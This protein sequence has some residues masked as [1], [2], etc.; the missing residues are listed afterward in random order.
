MQAAGT[1]QENALGVSDGDI[2][3]ALEP[4]EKRHPP[5]TGT[6]V[7]HDLRHRA[8]G[9]ERNVESAAHRNLHRGEAFEAGH[10]LAQPLRLDVGELETGGERAV[11]AGVASARGDGSG[12]SGDVDVERRFRGN[13]VGVTDEGDRRMGRMPRHSQASVVDHEIG[14]DDADTREIAHG[15]G[16]V[17]RR[18]QVGEQQVGGAARRHRLGAEAELD[19]AVGAAHDTHLGLDDL[20]ATRRDHAAQQRRKAEPERDLG[21]DRRQR[22]VG[23]HRTHVEK[24]DIEGALPAGP[25]EDGVAE[26][27]AVGRIALAQGVLDVGAEEGQR[28][29]PAG[30][31]PG[32]GGENDG[33]GGDGG[34][35]DVQD[36]A[37]GW[38][39]HPETPSSRLL[40][41]PRR[42]AHCAPNPGGAV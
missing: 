31:A 7:E 29:R 39:D 30:E 9:T 25:G 36:K 34:R 32:R 8:V 12:V 42:F 13:A 17:R 23:A 5:R 41:R 19:T 15:T 27:D 14:V 35:H 28:H 4:V 18:Q 37:A 38:A 20:E 2:E 6:E 26:L 3:F 1:D 24:P 22:P 16:G 10:A 40:D 11:G 33:G 21:R